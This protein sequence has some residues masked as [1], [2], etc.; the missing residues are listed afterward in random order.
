MP[1]LLTSMPA[2][3]PVPAAGLSRPARI[4]GYSV[5]A[6]A[7]VLGGGS[8]VM[9]AWSPK[10]IPLGLSPTAAL[11]WNA[12]LPFVFFTQ[13]SVMVRRSVR[14]RLAA[15]IPA[16][17]DGAFYAISSGVALT[18]V[19]LLYQRVEA[20]PLFVLPRLLVITAAFL[21]VA[22]FVWGIFTLH[23]FDPCGLHPIRRHLGYGPADPPEPRSR[24]T[25]VVAG[26]YR[27]VRHPLYSAVIVLLWADPEMTIG[28][29]ELAALWTAWICIGTLLEERDLTT[30]FGQTYREY[31]KQVP[32][33]IP[34]RGPAKAQPEVK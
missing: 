3:P 7:V 24:A 30:E 21:A 9:F 25:L 10:V 18:L 32:M 19:A 33:L 14:A 4:L 5:M 28:R 6:L 31:R 26:P 16:R 1:D 22:L 34:W 29:L 11:W 20:P 23:T 17:Y 2:H 12:L 15:V 27:W 8:L 13:H